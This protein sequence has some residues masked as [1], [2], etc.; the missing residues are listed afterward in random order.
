MTGIAMVIQKRL[1]SWFLANTIPSCAIENG[2]IILGA[3]L[4]NLDQ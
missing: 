2:D 1:S 4:N 3:Y